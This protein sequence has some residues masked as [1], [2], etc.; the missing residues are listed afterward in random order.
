MYVCIDSN[1]CEMLRP[2][3]KQLAICETS[4][5]WQTF[6]STI[7]ASSIQSQ[8]SHAAATSNAAAGPW[9]KEQQQQLAAAHA[10]GWCDT[11]Q[12]ALGSSSIN[13]R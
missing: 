12:C 8:L 1:L 10:S 3:F 9:V 13:S 6:T 7:S 5:T 2:S 4:N 11:E